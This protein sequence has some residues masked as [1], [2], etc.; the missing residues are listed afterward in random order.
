MIRDTDKEL[1]RDL[2]KFLSELHELIKKK[3]KEIANKP[4][5]DA[6]NELLLQNRKKDIIG[7]ERDVN[8]AIP[9][10][11]DEPYVYQELIAD[12]AEKAAKINKAISEIN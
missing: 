11:G 5:R 8:F 1:E 2:Q 3:E 6:T 10:L 4:K 9:A 7:F 12:F